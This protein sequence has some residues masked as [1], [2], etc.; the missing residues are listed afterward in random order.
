M[1]ALLTKVLEEEQEEEEQLSETQL[2][3]DRSVSLE[4]MLD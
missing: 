3:W 1:I 4:R 2:V